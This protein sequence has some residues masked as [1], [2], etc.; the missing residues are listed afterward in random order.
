MPRTS[1]VSLN[2]STC[3]KRSGGGASEG[4]RARVRERGGRAR[5]QPCEGGARKAQR[6]AACAAG[7]R[8]RHLLLG[9]ARAPY[10]SDDER[11][12]V[13]PNTGHGRTLTLV[14]PC[15]SCSFCCIL[16]ARSRFCVAISMILERGP[17]TCAREGA[18][19][20][21]RASATAARLPTSAARLQTSAARLRLGTCSKVSRSSIRVC[22]SPSR[23]ETDALRGELVMSALSPKHECMLSTPISCRRGGGGVRGG[24]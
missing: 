3:Q 14:R 6:C 15:A 11:D 1:R 18:R 12:T 22:S 9:A 8:V 10:R 16:A 2:D 23:D 21:E 13:R 24:E 20:R 17:S 7:P 19:A 5:G 4:P